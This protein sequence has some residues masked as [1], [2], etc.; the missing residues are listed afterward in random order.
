M[1]Q[2][3][4]FTHKSTSK[5]K[6]KKRTVEKPLGTVTGRI[7]RCYESHPALPIGDFKIYGGSCG[8]PI[9]KDADVY[10]GFD[11]SM[12]FFNSQYPWE[13][14]TREVVEFLYPITDMAAPSK[15]KE[16]HQL[17]G[18]LAE[19]LEGGKKVHIGCIGGHG[20][21]GTVLAALVKHMT[22]NADAISYVREHY[23]KKAVESK[24]Q[25]KFLEEQFGIEPAAAL[26]NSYYT[27]TWKEPK[28]S[29]TTYLYTSNKE[30]I[31]SPMD[32]PN[33][34]GL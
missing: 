20:R 21:T 27:P 28:S 6:G 31:V 10:V 7:P 22:G 19:Q 34:W 17:I 30:Y 3:I 18:W 14:K 32:H 25:V 26:K 24:V 29:S 2:A 13:E 11:R 4:D 12:Q 33:I 15:P 5:R 1:T 8:H 23:C 9:V 16:F